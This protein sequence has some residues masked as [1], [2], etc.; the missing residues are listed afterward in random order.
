LARPPVLCA[1]S[2]TSNLAVETA[3]AFGLTG[4]YLRGARFNIYKHETRVVSPELVAS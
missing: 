4:G 1:V 2:A 3:R